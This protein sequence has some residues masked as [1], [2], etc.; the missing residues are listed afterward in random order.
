MGHARDNPEIPPVLRQVLPATTL[1]SWSVTN[2]S[3]VSAAT[4][5]I[6]NGSRLEDLVIRTVRTKESMAYP[7]CRNCQTWLPGED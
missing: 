3:E 2:C 7:P 5:A 6:N 4:S 1:E